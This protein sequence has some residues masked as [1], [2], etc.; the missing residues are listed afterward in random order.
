MIVDGPLIRLNNRKLA[1]ILEQYRPDLVGFSL[2]SLDLYLTASYLQLIR[3]TLPNAVTVVG[4]PHSSGEPEDTFYNYIP[5][6]DYAFVGEGEKGLRFLADLLD[7]G[8]PTEKDLKSVPGLVYKKG[9][10]FYKNT[11]YIE[12]DLDSLGFPAWDLI[13]PRS[14]P[15]APHAGFAR[16]FPVATISA[17]RGC[18][19]SCEYCAASTIQGKGIRRRSIPHII[20]EISM[21]VERYGVLIIAITRFGSVKNWRG[22]SLKLCGTALM[23]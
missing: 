4:G 15:P 3:K 2:I 18:P 20:E 16:N 8:R 21:L 12:Q 11:A 17:T 14:Y 19:F 13:D 1:R 23:A 6:L 9:V 7:G 5:D 22:G 10:K